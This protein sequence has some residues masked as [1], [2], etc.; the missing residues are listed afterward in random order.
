MA[1]EMS[2]QWWIQ[3]FLEGVFCYNLARKIL[4]ATPILDKT[5]S[6]SIVFERS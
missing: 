6:I 3:D 1:N 5:T 2:E 4:E